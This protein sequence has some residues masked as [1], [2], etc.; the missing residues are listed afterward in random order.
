M[1]LTLQRKSLPNHER[2]KPKTISLDGSDRKRKIM[3]AHMKRE[4]EKLKARLLEVSAAAEK[5]LCLAVESLREKDSG[6]AKKVI[7]G[8][9]EI[10][11]IQVIEVHGRDRSRTG[12]NIH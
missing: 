6:L 10:D 1:K 5:N 12:H 9:I 3:T 7:D 11:H 4:I 8:D 2:K